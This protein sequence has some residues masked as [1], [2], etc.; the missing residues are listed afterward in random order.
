MLRLDELTGVVGTF[1]A[2]C[3]HA[4]GN[5]LDREGRLV[6]CEHGGRRVSRTEHDGSITTIVDRVDGKRLNSPNDAIVGRDG[7]IWFTDPSYGID[8]DYEGRRAD[9][10]IGACH[11]YRV[12]A[13][14]GACRV[15]ADDF[16]RPNGLAFADDE[17]TL[18]VVDSRIDHIRRFGVGT[19]GTL[20]DDGVFAES[21]AGSFD[22]IRL[23]STGRIWAAA[24]DGVHCFA[25][26]GTLIGKLLLPEPVSNLVF[27]GLKRNHLFV[28]ATTS[29]YAIL[30]NVNGAPA[31]WQP[32]G[33]VGVPSL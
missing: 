19:D 6:T 32:A 23:D 21:T 25:P 8:S 12:D 28:T 33:G 11:V 13:A 26:D 20:T 30:L 9:S 31:P 15:V 18:Y 2:P 1:R 3:G 22:G 7:S 24:G 29:V 5:T 17:R 16:V 10:E 4:N 14:T 27:G